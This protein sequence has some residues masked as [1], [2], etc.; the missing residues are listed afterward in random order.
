MCLSKVLSS[1]TESFNPDSLVHRGTALLTNNKQVNH[2]VKSHNKIGWLVSGFCL[3]WF[4]SAQYIFLAE[5]LLCRITENNIVVYLQEFATENWLAE[6]DRHAIHGKRGQ[7]VWPYI[8]MMD[9]SCVMW[10]NL[11]KQ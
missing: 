7:D 1:I 11:L 9:D 4:F 10:Q 6:R 5:S 8:F 2:I 3:F